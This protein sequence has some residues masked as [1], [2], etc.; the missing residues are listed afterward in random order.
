MRAISIRLLRK[1]MM[2]VTA[3]YWMTVM[4]VT[5]TRVINEVINFSTGCGILERACLEE[6]IPRI[7]VCKNPAYSKRILNRLDRA[8]LCMVVTKG[9]VLYEADAKHMFSKVS[10]VHGHFD[11]SNYHGLSVSIG[12]VSDVESSFS[13]YARPA[14]FTPFSSK[15]RALNRHKY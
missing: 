5:M 3:R 4:T 11:G 2:F 12:I 13:S 14:V 1:V 9:T 15:W 10:A 7:A 8:I 6:G